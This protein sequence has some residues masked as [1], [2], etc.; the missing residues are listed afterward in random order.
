MRSAVPPAI[1]LSEYDPEWPKLAA[2]YADQLGVLGPV[3]VAVHHIGSTSVPGLLAKPIVDLMPLV[4]SL[5]ELDRGRRVVEDLGYR[6][7]GEYGIPG[8]R[9]CSLTDENDVRRAHVHFFAALSGE[10]ERHLAFRDYLRTHPAVA[11]AYAAEKRRARELH[12]NG[13]AG[14]TEEKAAWVRA[15]ERAALAWHAGADL[16]GDGSF[17]DE[18]P[19]P[20]LTTRSRV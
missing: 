8:R 4:T 1:V 13:M 2:R 3:L 18:S 10:A 6:W 7:Y 9:Y 20:F 15:T 19:D 11:R 16:A 12:P 17:P 14:Y 5:A